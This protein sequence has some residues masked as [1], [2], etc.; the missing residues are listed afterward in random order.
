M[1]N[2]SWRRASTV[3]VALWAAILSPSR[4]QAQPQAQGF[5]VERFY[6][7]APGAGWFVMD[8]LDMQGG[9]GGAMALTLGYA[10]N[11][12]RISDG[13][14]GLSVVSDEAS[15]NFGFALTYSRFRLS[16]NM[17]MP[18]VITGGSGMAGS[19]RSHHERD[20]QKDACC[21]TAHAT[22]L[23]E[24]K[25]HKFRRDPKCPD[26]VNQDK[27]PQVKAPSVKAPSGAPCL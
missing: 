16:L 23:S 6:P 14:Q 17:D 8:A 27:A 11:P 24:S 21:G 5:A 19:N 25:A 13:S 7:S 26:E 18:F 3:V 10:R 9:L 12:L 22:L 15:A 20:T 2:S 4:A 1:L